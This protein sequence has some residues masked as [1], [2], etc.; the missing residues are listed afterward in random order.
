MLDQRFLNGDTWGFPG[1]AVEHIETHAAHVFLCSDR[2]FKIKKNVKLPYLD[3]STVEKRKSILER[4]L[5]INR[6]FAAD[7]YLDVIEKYG[8][9]VLAMKRFA[10]K[11]ILSYL[12]SDGGVD[13]RLSMALATTIFDSHK[14]TVAADISGADIMTGL[15]KQLSK[16]FHDSPDIFSRSAVQEF[17]TLYDVLLERLTPLLNARGANGLVRR[18]HGDMHCGNIVVFNA[19]PVLFDAIEFSEK[20]ATI[21]VLY[22]LAFLLMDLM[23]FDQRRAA[24]LILNAYLNLRHVEEDLT[25]LAALPLFL[26]TRAGVRALVTA[27]LVHELEGT[28]ANKQVEQAQQHF[29]D[30]MDFLKPKKPKLICIGGVSGTGKTTLARSLAPFID[31]PPGAIHIRSDVERKILAGADETQRLSADHYTESNSSKVYEAV[32]ARTR[33]ALSAGHSVIVDAVFGREVERYAV[34]SLATE[35]DLK[36]QGL[37]LEGNPEILKRRVAGRVN[38]ASDATPQVVDAQIRQRHGEISWT[39]I[40]ASGYPEQIEASAKTLI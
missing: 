2:A 15:K 12:A 28:K 31:P 10:T 1:S 39:R 34:Q 19:K 5:E 18:C 27:D 14:R 13:D 29:K 9:P 16:A 40:D 33:R 3:F 11:S 8:E 30:C 26:A 6:T 24:N 32:F 4:E 37:W 25:G 23:K 38:D 21:D 17:D 35:L 22:D 36:F 7:I 20:I